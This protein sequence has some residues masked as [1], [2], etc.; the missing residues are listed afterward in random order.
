MEAAKQLYS[1]GLVPT[2]LQLDVENRDSITRAKEEVRRS[3]GRV[4]VLVNNAAVLHR[5]S[6]EARR[7]AVERGSF[8]GGEGG[9]GSCRSSRSL[10]MKYGGTA[11]T[12]AWLW[13]WWL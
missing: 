8:E 13:V 4:D 3:Y 12:Q 9:G 5:V 10:H 6:R 11:I 2:I 7:E 1:E